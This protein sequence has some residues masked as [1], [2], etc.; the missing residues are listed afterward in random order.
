MAKKK[1]RVVILLEFVPLLLIYCFLRMLSLRAAYLVSRQM[2]LLFFR[3][4]GRHRRWTISHLLHAGMASDPKEAASMARRIFINFSMTIV[5]ICK[6]DQL[7]QIDKIRVTGNEE[8]IRQVGPGTKR[9]VI[10]VTAHYGNWELAGSA[11]SAL[12]GI[13]ILSVMRKFDNPLVGRYIVHQRES[14]T[15]HCVNKD[16]S[17]KA[18]LKALHGGKHIAILADQHANHK[19]GV[20]NVFFGQPCRTHTSPALLHLKTG[21]PIMPAITRR[22]GNDFRFEIVLG[23][24]IRYQPTEDKAADILALTQQITTE[25][26]QLIRKD[27][28]QWMWAHRRWLNINR[29]HV[30]YSKSG[31]PLPAADSAKDQ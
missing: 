17:I 12:T 9:N 26:E 14:S 11:W 24:L 1:S 25:L 13:P 2:V 6:I 30:R 3:M 23:N 8:T 5:E 27:P 19:E 20:E 28:E 18:M 22:I 29:R 4:D 15:H 16:G 31:A 7:L 21:V 10:I